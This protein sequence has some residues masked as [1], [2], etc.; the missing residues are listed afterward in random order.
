MFHFS[1]SSRQRFSGSENKVKDRQPI[2]LGK[3]KI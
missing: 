3:E 1:Q 2:Q